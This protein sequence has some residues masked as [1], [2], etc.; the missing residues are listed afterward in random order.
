MSPIPALSKDIYKNLARHLDNL[1]GGYP[2]TDSGVELRILKHLFNAEEAELAVRLTLIPE[3]VHVIS[4]RAGLPEKKTSEILENM[5]GKGL[6]FTSRK[7]NGPKCYMAAQFVVGIWEY[8]VG[9]LTDELVSDM[10]EYIPFLF[11]KKAWQKVPQM[12]TVPVNRSIKP[13][14]NVMSYEKAEELVKDKYNFVVTPCICRKEMNMKDEGCDKP[15]D[16]CISF[17][18]R[19]NYYL[20]QGYGRTATRDEVLEILKLADKKGLVL[21]PSNSKNISWLCCCC[22][23]CCGI[24]RTLK[25]YPNPGDFVFSPFYAKGNDQTCSTCGVCLKR[26]PMDAITLLEDK[27]EVDRNR[28]IGCGLCVSTCPTNFLSLHRKEPENQ[29]KIPGTIQTSMLKLAWKRGKTGPVDLAK[30]VIQSKKDRVLSRFV[31]TGK[32]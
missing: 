26:C 9:H 13:E 19:N 10:E 8:Q 31:T 14:H 17:G 2:E 22:G 20:E 11:D 28:C 1:P 3:P 24:L 18:H 12:R 29:R 25:K 21:Q 4:F 32:G 27:V 16:T 6:V 7:K 5:T 30:L 15:L 23:C